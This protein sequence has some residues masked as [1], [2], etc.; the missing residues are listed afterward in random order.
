MFAK[1]V[2]WTQNNQARTNSLFLETA[3]RDDVPVMT[4]EREDSDLPCLKSLFIPLVTRDPTEVT[5]AETV[6]NDL[7]Y[8]NKLTEA[9]FF[10]KYLEEWRRI[11]S[12]R[13]KK[14][15]FEAIIREIEED[16]RSSFTAAKYLIE[17]PW[18]PKDKTTRKKVKDTTS[19]AFSAFSDDIAR[20][21]EQ[22]LIQ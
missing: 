6:F 14:L 2:L 11:A 22:N 17:E 5:F 8:W 3:L 18:L 16:G 19:E 9:K 21:K 12:V 7:S 1:E 15:A 20:L 10:Q 13:R 4:L